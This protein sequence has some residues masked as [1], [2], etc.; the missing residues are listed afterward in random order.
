MTTKHKTVKMRYKTLLLCK[1][2]P[3]PLFFVY[4]DV[5]GE[6]I[7]NYKTKEVSLVFWRETSA[8]YRIYN[9]NVMLNHIIL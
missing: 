1:R 3:Q 6:G 9:I 5:M 8:V 7:F 4:T 2:F